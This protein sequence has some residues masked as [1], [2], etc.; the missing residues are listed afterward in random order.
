M[1]THNEIYEQRAQELQMRIRA[2]NDL[3]ER[4][5]KE[6]A[7]K[8]IRTMMDALSVYEYGKETG[9]ITDTNNRVF[10]EILMSHF[11]NQ[12]YAMELEIAKEQETPAETL[13][14]LSNSKHADVVN[15]VMSNRN[16]PRHILDR[17]IHIQPSEY[18]LYG[19]V[20]FANIL[21]NPNTSNAT[22]VEFAGDKLEKEELR[23]IA[24]TQIHER[25]REERA[26]LRA[27][28]RKERPRKVEHEEDECELCR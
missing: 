6:C 14:H 4:D 8:K 26:A 18:E 21:Y 13:E 20:K 19:D 3:I 15:Y 9:F 12:V 5:G 10:T 17:H 28:E 23:Q 11:E 27:E 1:T 25:I 16:T 2:I 22:L 7:K 24:K